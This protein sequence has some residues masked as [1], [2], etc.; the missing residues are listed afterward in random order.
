MPNWA[1]K[2]FPINLA[3]LCILGACAAT[4]HEDLILPGLLDIPLVEGSKF[5]DDCKTGDLLSDVNGKAVCVL[6]KP[7]K[8]DSIASDGTKDWTHIYSSLLAEDGW[9]FVQ[10]HGT[11]YLL[12][13]PI[14]E[15]ECSE[16]LLFT[17]WPYGDY[18]E[19]KIAVE[20]EDFSKLDYATFTFSYLDKKVCDDKRLHKP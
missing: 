4:T 12:E 10:P 6:V 16:Q 7:E 13:R 1:G 15:T 8:D 5:V 20:T 14:P 3:T 17:W 2:L 9:H 18:K 19:A 11:H